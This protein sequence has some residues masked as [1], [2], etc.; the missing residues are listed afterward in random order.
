MIGCTTTLRCVLGSKLVPEERSRS[1]RTST[2]INA[3]RPNTIMNVTQ[4]SRKNGEGGTMV[5]S[6]NTCPWCQPPPGIHFLSCHLG[7]GQMLALKKQLTG[8]APTQSARAHTN[9]FLR[10][11]NANTTQNIGE[12]PRKPRHT[13]E[14]RQL[15]QTRTRKRYS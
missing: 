10:R 12:S 15:Q 3:H 5:V 1:A 11:N 6:K 8:N 2:R 13:S 14:R 7:G 4:D 9:S